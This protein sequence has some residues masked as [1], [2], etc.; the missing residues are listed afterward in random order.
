MPYNNTPIA[1]SSEVT[2]TVAL[3]RMHF[4]PSLHPPSRLEPRTSTPFPTLTYHELQVL[5]L[6]KTKTSL[7]VARVKKIIN[8]D[9]DIS[10]CSNNA[11]FVI[12]VAT[13]MFLQHLVEQAY[14]QVKSEHATKPRRN[15]QYRDVGK[16]FFFFLSF[17]ISGSL[18]FLLKEEKKKIGIYIDEYLTL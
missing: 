13:E 7:L 5:P 1:P 11:A 2:G 4:P 14:T 15:I 3:P 8:T 9:P 10:Q 17:V 12:T 6:T 16:N 18:P